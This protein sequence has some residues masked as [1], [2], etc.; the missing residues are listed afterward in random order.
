MNR[1]SNQRFFCF[2]YFWKTT[3]P[4]ILFI[5]FSGRAYLL[6]REQRYSYSFLFRN[7]DVKNLPATTLSLQRVALQQRSQPAGHMTRFCWRS[8]GFRLAACS[9]FW[10]R[11]PSWKSST[12]FAT[13]GQ[14][15]G[16]E[17]TSS[18]IHKETTLKISPETCVCACVT[19]H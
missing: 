18:S 8:F 1:Q 4:F 2:W 11:T 6:L 14:P 12:S 13:L 10:P 16:P 15:C 7:L 17:S 9:L 19:T 5:I 3:I